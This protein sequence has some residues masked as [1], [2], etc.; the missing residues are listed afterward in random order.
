[1][2]P[3]TRTYASNTR[4]KKLNEMNNPGTV[5]VEK[6]SNAPTED[7]IETSQNTT[8]NKYKY[9]TTSKTYTLRDER[10]P[11]GP[12]N[13]NLRPTPKK[14]GITQYFNRLWTKIKPQEKN[15]EI[16]EIKK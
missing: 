15:G 11:L 5:Q 7:P 10:V 16:R 3:E 1:M 6:L 14:S 9:S 2:I 4:M 12:A 13:K 8:D